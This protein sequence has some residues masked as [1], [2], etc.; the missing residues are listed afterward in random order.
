MAIQVSTERATH[1][2]S[3]FSRPDSGP[4]VQQVYGRLRLRFEAREHRNQTILTESDQQLPLRIV[5]AFKLDDGSAL[6]H[7]HNL[8]GV[9]WAAIS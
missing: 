8:S 5:R 2:T 4:R 3:T 6:V 7:L 9:S 1:E